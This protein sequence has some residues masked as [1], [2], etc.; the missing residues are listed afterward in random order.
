MVSFKKTIAVCAGI[1]IA[2]SAF[3][4]SAAQ[5]EQFKKL[6][7]AQQE[8]LA[9]QYGVDLNALPSVAG[10]QTAQQLSN[11]V[12]VVPTTD[13]LELEQSAKEAEKVSEGVVKDGAEEQLTEKSEERDSQVEELSLFGYD[14]FAGAP[15]TFAPATDIPVPLQY[16][17][18]P[19]DNIKLHMYGKVNTQVQLV[20]DRDGKIMIPD[21]GPLHVAGVS[22][23]QLKELIDE[24]VKQRALGV[25]VITMLGEMRC[26]RVFIMGEATRPGS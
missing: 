13:P 24:E 12:V 3:A 20:V 14:T 25:N 4:Q 11:P 17:I 15:T 8:A 23:G 1:A 22:Y 2:S 21:V 16:V 9:S 6:P 5:I 19:G 26:V 10:A 7:R 18:G